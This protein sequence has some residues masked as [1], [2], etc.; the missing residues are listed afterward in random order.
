M[1]NA[2]SQKNTL[3]VMALFAI[4]IMDSMSTAVVLELGVREYNPIMN[5]VLKQGGIGLLVLVKLL[6]V[7][8]AVIPLELARRKGLISEKRHRNYYLVTI[9]LY[10]GI[11]GFFFALA[12]FWSAGVV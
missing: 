7:V 11:Y 12:N 10:L 4:C 1:E 5:F 8:L 3:L 9:L 2:L 6:T